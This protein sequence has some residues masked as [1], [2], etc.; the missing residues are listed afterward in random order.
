MAG[1]LWRKTNMEHINKMTSTLLP[2]QTFPLHQSE[3]YELRST[4]KIM[5]PEQT[6]TD[7][8]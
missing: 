6:R 5:Q 8:K 7:C 4:N 2:Y 1:G 3:T